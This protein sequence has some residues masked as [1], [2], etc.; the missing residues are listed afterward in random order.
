[1]SV[2]TYIVEHKIVVDFRG[3]PFEEQFAD[4]DDEHLVVAVRDTATGLC[5]ALAAATDQPAD[6]VER[7]ARYQ[8][9]LYIAKRARHNEAAGDDSDPRA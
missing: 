8:L 4:Y 2:D 9:A 1:M 5:C 7:E 6:G 3:T